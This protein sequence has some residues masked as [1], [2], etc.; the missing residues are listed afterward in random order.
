MASS[1]IG[2]TSACRQGLQAT[3]PGPTGCFAP[4]YSPSEEGHQRPRAHIQVGG[5]GCTFTGSMSS[6]AAI[7]A[8]KY[9]A[10]NGICSALPPSNL[11]PRKFR[12]DATSSR[13]R[14]DAVVLSVDVWSASPP[15]AV[16]LVVAIMPAHTF[17]FPN[18]PEAES[19]AMPWMTSTSLVR[20]AFC[21]P[22]E[23]DCM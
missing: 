13:S 9:G 20:E 10:S 7:N 6:I 4:L 18:W 11:M 5:P 17:A 22:A 8:L 1:N 2:C 3:T 15:S 21:H 12:P 19:A 14:S 23:L 16:T